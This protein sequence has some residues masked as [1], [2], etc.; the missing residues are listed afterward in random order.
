[1]AK[2]AEV[3]VKQRSKVVLALLR[4]EDP[5]TQLARR[6]NRPQRVVDDDDSRSPVNG[7]GGQ[8][9]YRVPRRKLRVHYR[10]RGEGA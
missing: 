6:A 4:R 8:S 7:A 3:S 9:I 5:A 10:W 2:R 1:M